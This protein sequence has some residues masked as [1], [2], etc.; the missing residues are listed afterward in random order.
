[1][2]GRGK[3]RW[4]LGALAGSL[5][6]TV[7]DKPREV[8]L[9]QA[10]NPRARDFRLDVIG[11]AYHKSLL[12]DEGGGVYVARVKP[13]AEGWTAFF[14]ELTYDMPGQTPIKF[15]TQGEVVVRV[16]SAQSCWGRSW[17]PTT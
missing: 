4:G 11:P 16:R 2:V 13:P 15:T 7:K 6:V 8:N 17:A 12:Q 3:R 14:A 5:V 1:M 10:T 9:W